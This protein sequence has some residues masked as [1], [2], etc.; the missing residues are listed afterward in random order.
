MGIRKAI[1]RIARNEAKK[2][3]IPVARL[4]DRTVRAFFRQYSCRDKYD[5]AALLATRFPDLAWRLPPRP[6]FYDPEPG[7]MLYF[8]SIALGLA[9]LE[10][11]DEN[12][13]IS[14]ADGGILSPAS[15]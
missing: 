7:P 12:N 8:D 1:V 10:R 2:R 3:S 13:Q 4:S 11:T 15:K 14:N 5:V 6:K 9:Y